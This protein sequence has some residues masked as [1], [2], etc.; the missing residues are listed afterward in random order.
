[1]E[2]FVSCRLMH[3]THI[4]GLFRSQGRG[5]SRYQWGSYQRKWSDEERAGIRLCNCASLPR[6]AAQARSARERWLNIFEDI[7][8]DLGKH[9]K[10]ADW[11][12][13][14]KRGREFKRSAGLRTTATVCDASP[15]LSRPSDAIIEDSG[16]DQGKENR[17]D[18]R[19]DVL[20]VS[21]PPCTG[22]P[23]HH[24]P[25]DPPPAQHARRELPRC[26]DRH[27]RVELALFRFDLRCERVYLVGGDVAYP[28]R[29]K[30][31]LVGWGVR[32]RD[33]Y[34]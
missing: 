15:K 17:E 23:A 8:D 12:N 21:T 16:K 11:L 31:E 26:F 6:Y 25:C 32:Y 2:I 3:W 7:L 13:A 20:G 30:V 29:A 28:Q 22:R 27:A 1:M 5:V 9:G 34:L 33:V 10:S 4:L 19:S 24:R 14:I 18:S